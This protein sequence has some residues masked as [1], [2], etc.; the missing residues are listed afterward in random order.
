MCEHVWMGSYGVRY[1]YDCYAKEVGV[2]RVEARLTPPGLLALRPFR[3]SQS[4]ATFS[5]GLQLALASRLTI[6][7]HFF[8]LFPG[9]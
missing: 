2:T 8:L 5:H 7:R 6:G 3:C 1:V 4:L 9:F